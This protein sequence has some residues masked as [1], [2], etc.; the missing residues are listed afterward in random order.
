VVGIKKEEIFFHLGEAAKHL[1]AMFK[2]LVPDVDEDTLAV[3]TVAAFEEV[4]N[5]IDCDNDFTWKFD[6]LKNDF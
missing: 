1:F 3:L 4:L 6:I 5:R 2:I